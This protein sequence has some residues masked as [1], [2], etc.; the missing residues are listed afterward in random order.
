MRESDWSSDVC[1]SDLFPSHDINAHDM[2]TG[3]D[4]NGITAIPWVGNFD[5]RIIKC[6]KHVSSG[7]ESDYEGSDQDQRQNGQQQ[8][9]WRWTVTFLRRL[10]TRR[11]P[12]RHHL[13]HLL[14]ILLLVV[15][16]QQCFSAP[17]PDSQLDTSPV[18][19]APFATIPWKWIVHL[20]HRNRDCQ[21]QLEEKD[22]ILLRRDL[23]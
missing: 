15:P 14:V 9:Q 5:P 2:T 21:A 1:S 12:H 19:I 18:E 10:G 22:E 3:G 23:S 8:Q 6:G 20:I 13:Y 4:K 7:E 17:I 11:V 16:I